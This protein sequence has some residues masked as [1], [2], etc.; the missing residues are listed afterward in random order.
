[1]SLKKNPNRKP[2]K[3][4]TIPQEVEK[5]A[6]LL[7]KLVR[8]KASNSLGFCECVT[9]GVIKHYKEMQGGHFYGRKEALVFK[10]YEENLAVQCA[11]CNWHGMA[12]TKIRERYRMYMEDMYGVSRVKAMNRLAFR[13]PPK[14]KM[15]EVLEFKKY[16]RDQIKIQLRRLGE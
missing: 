1:M 9:C 10:L 14:F 7:Q 16:L 6:V 11:R 15:D 2:R 12:T 3:K 8:L 4:P 13:K 5:A